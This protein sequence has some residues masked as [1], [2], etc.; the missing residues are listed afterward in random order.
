M[1]VTVQIRCDQNGCT[2]VYEVR[3]PLGINAMAEARD[4]GGWKVDLGS[5]KAKCPLHRGRGGAQLM[6]LG[7]GAL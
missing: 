6:R 5:G 7:A 3:T 4:E 1:T 2:E